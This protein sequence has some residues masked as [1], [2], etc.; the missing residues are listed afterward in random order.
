MY[1]GYK[2][3]EVVME[4]SVLFFKMY[5]KIRVSVCAP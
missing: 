2:F 4:T 3:T 5:V 1:L